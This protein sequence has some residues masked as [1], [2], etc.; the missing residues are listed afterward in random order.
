[1]STTDT[2]PSASR[3]VANGSPSRLGGSAIAVIL[4]I[5]A[6]FSNQLGAALGVQLFPQVGAVAVVSLRLTLAALVLLALTRPRLRGYRR[7]DWAA[8]LRSAWCSRQ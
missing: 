1:M 7:S 4:V 2:S 6:A 3:P 8:I 5:T